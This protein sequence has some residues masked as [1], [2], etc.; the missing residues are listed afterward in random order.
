MQYLFILLN[1]VYGIG[2]LLFLNGFLL[3]R[4]TILQNST[5]ISSQQQFKNGSSE[6]NQIVLLVIDAL[7]YDFIQ[8]QQHTKLNPFYHNQMSHVQQ[9]LIRHPRQARLVKLHADPPT[10]TLQRLKALTT[11]T[12][13]TFIDFSYNFFGYEV[14]EDNILFQS[15]NN[16]KWNI[17]FLGD[18]TWLTLY[19]TM[20]HRH[21]AYPSF[22]VYDL[23]TVDNGILEHLDELIKQQKSFIIA[24]FLGV[25]HCGHRYSPSHTE[26]S[27][28]LRQ[29]DMVI[30]NITSQLKS[31]S[32]L[33][34]VG[35]HGMTSSGDHGGD[36]LNEIETAMFVYTNKQNYFTLLEDSSTT[37]HYSQ[38]DFVPTL[39]WYLQILVP[40]SNLGFVINELIPEHEHLDAMK[41]NFNQIRLYLSKLSS[42]DSTLKLSNEL[43]MLYSRLNS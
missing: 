26:M 9:L 20:F 34:V 25:D 7:R 1:I 14:N 24:H 35:D 38:M 41:Q 43:T 11:G 27:R 15:H 32:L 22:N 5:D 13:P 8:P 30:L 18:D 40:Y 29:M 42:V 23:D 17:S 33:I 28:K 39:S 12:L 2:L 19:P 21:H 37:I 4:R 6:F 10:T 3:T 16:N 36:E 31:N